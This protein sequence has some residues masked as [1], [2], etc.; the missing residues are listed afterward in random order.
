M[1]IRELLKLVPP[2]EVPIDSGD[3]AIWTQVQKQLGTR[4]P[5]DFRDIG[6][7]YGTGRFGGFLGIINPFSPHFDSQMPYLLRV[8][9]EIRHSR[10]YAHEVFPEK[11]G[12]L[13]CGGDDNGN[14]LHWLTKGQ[15]DRWPIIAEAHGGEL[16]IFEMSMTT[17]LCKAFRN[18]IRPKYMWGMPFSQDELVFVQ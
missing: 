3:D 16:E 7:H 14:M 6:T 18:E 5:K 15:V 12:L 2:P 11:P 9:R 1:S 4:L 8:L 10:N 13:P 17:F